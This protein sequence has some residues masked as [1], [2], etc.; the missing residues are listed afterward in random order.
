MPVPGWGEAGERRCARGEVVREGEAER[1]KDSRDCKKKWGGT[2]GR[3][4]GIRKGP[5]GDRNGE[6]KREGR[7]VYCVGGKGMLWY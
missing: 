7:I 5:K 4:H 6:G 3:R 1:R 2:G